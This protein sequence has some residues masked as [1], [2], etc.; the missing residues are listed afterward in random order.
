MQTDM[1][2][3]VIVG[4]L[5]ETNLRLKDIFN[6]SESVTLAEAQQLLPRVRIAQERA[7]LVARKAD[8]PIPEIAALLQM[9]VDDYNHIASNILEGP[10]DNVAEIRKLL[11]G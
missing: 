2:I 11:L 6:T 1:F 10:W 5:K 7:I 4:M 8:M 3:D 9:E